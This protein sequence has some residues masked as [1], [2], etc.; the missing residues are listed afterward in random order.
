MGP[1]DYNMRGGGGNRGYRGGRG[2]GRAGGPRRRR[3]TNNEK[4]VRW[5]C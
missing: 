3:G 5:R 4:Y 2:R 1:N